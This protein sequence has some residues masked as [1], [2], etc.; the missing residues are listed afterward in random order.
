MQASLT[1]PSFSGAKHRGTTVYALLL[2]GEGRKPPYASLHPFAASTGELTEALKKMSLGLKPAASPAYHVT[3]WLPTR[4]DSPVPSGALIAEPPRSRAKAKLA[5]WT[6]A[7]YRFSTAE[8]VKLLC[9]SIGKR[10]LAAGVIVGV[11]L[12]YWAEALRFAGSMMARQQFLPGFTTDT[13]EPRATWDPVFIGMDTERLAGLARRMPAAARALSEPDAA[14]PPEMPSIAVLRQF[15]ATLADYLVRT[16]TSDASPPAARRRKNKLPFDS[17]HDSWLHALRSI[18]GVVEGDTADLA[19]LAAQVREWRRPIAVS[20]GSPFRLCFR[21]E[22]P[23]D[24]A[25]TEKEGEKV[26]GDAWYVRYLLQPCDD[27]SLLI[28]VDEA[29]KAGGRKISAL[30][31]NG[32]NVR[33]FL[34][35]SLGQASGICPRITASLENAK[36][37]GYPLDAAKAHQFLTEESI[38]LEQA[39][40]S[41]MLP[42]WWTRKGTKVRLAVRANVK[43]PKMQGG[44]GL[45]LET[46]VQFD[47]EVALGDR[48]LTLRELEALARMKAPLVR[49]RGQWVE[50]NAAEIQAAID[51]WK[52]K[53]AEKATFR[54]IIQMALGAG[55]APLGLDF[56][57]VK[58]TGWIGKLLKQ[59]DG[60]AAFK[61][62]APPK[63]FSGTLRPYQVRGYSWLSFLRQWG[64]G[65]CLADDMGLGKTIQT[66]A[67]TQRDWQTN[68]KRPVLLVCPPPW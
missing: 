56:N 42:A 25:T 35:S 7:A 3:A 48:K 46:I 17:V 4:G 24:T 60:Q 30:K 57:G 47:W 11:D 34:L 2:G 63:A 45:S 23:E 33:E 18:D 55:D 59:M 15:V 49:V 9:A 14:E 68:G 6:V 43:S 40:Y 54:D 65:A 29:W 26:S 19:Q 20:A 1:A 51:F 66:L 8:A 38:A 41:V 31:R 61:E 28:P 62:L 50:V 52:K 39:G 44:S 58:A 13:D 53:G 5:P 22:E 37:A 27:P 32:S 12:A 64:L 36:P 10:M 16:A 67:L 21:L